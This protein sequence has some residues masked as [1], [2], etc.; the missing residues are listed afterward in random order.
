MF[1]KNFS[2]SKSEA[3]G[4]VKGRNIN[5][6]IYGPPGPQLHLNLQLLAQ[7][8]GL[9]ITSI[10]RIKYSPGQLKTIKIHA[11][12]GLDAIFGE[13]TTLFCRIIKQ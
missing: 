3:H 10:L 13:K 8:I 5:D 12:K 1:W 9:P 2:V 7:T 4:L 6:N 11:L